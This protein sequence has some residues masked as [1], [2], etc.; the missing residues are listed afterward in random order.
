[1]TEKEKKDQRHQE[2]LRIAD[3]TIWRGTY[4][5]GGQGNPRKSFKDPVTSAFEA[6][7]LANGRGRDRFGNP[8]FRK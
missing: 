3:R 2:N 6:T 5:E 7:I 1:M 4:Y 8:I